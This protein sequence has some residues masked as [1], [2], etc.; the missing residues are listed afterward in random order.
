MLTS[1][2]VCLCCEERGDR[3][4]ERLAD[5]E[6]L[7]LFQEIEQ[8]PAEDKTVIKIFINDGFNEE[9]DKPARKIKYEINISLPCGNT[10]KLLTTTTKRGSY[11]A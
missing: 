7:K 2:T 5:H 3:G 8:L 1:N 4:K 11:Y 10:I 9:A 6:L